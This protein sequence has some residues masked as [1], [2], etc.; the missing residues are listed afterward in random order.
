MKS[1]NVSHKYTAI[2]AVTT[3]VRHFAVTNRTLPE[4]SELVILTYDGS[5]IFGLVDKVEQELVRESGRNDGL[6][7]HCYGISDCEIN[8][9]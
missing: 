6:Y 2:T 3:N 9:R 1:A 5:Q 8:I 7:Y 4:E